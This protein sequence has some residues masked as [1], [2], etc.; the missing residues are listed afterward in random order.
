MRACVYNLLVNRVP[1][2]RDRYQKRRNQKGTSRLTALLFLLW[3]NVQ[4]YLLF[5]RELAFPERYPVYEE[6][7]LPEGESESSRSQREDPAS[8]AEKLSRCDVVSFDVFDTLLLRVV[9][10]PTDVFFFVGMS[11]SY[12]NFRAIRVEMEKKVREQKRRDT[13]SGEV[14]LAEIWDGVAPETGID[15]TLGMQTE[16]WWEK[17]CC[18][19][20]PYMKQVVECLRAKG[21][22]IIAVS[23]MYLSKGHI[24]SL[25]SSCGYPSVLDCF[26][27]CE[28]GV[29]KGEGTLFDRV[30]EQVGRSYSYVHV[31]DHEHADYHQPRRHHMQAFLSLNVN[32]IG[33]R[34]RPS[35]M[36]AITGAVYRG[37]ANAHLHNG[38]TAYS[39]EYEYGYLYGGLFVTGYCRFIHRYAKEHGMQRLLFLS[40]DGAVLLKAYR[41]MYPQEADTAVYAYWSRLA[42]VKLAARYYKWEYFQR[43]LYHKVD[44]QIPLSQIVKSMELS[45]MLPDLCRRTHTTPETFLTNKNVHSVQ[46]YF[47]EA[48]E[49]VLA[50]YEPQ[51]EAGKAY[52]QKLLHGC[53][54]AAAIDVGWAG[55]GAVM[56][57]CMVNRVWGLSCPITGILAGGPS[58]LSPQADG[59]EPF[60]LNGKLV[61]Y[62]YSQRENR[63]LWKFHDPAQSHNLYWE[64]LLGAPHGSLKGF[65]WDGD[66]KATCRFQ[67]SPKEP[68][69]IEEIHRGVLAFVEQFLEA[70]R[71]LAMEIPISGRDAYAPMLLA[72]SRGNRKFRKGLEELLDDVHIG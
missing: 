5:R 53:D 33:N 50:Q 28:Y 3:L 18:I 32:H 11:L 15:K 10:D 7:R 20:N 65:Y 52:Y 51:R 16:L 19:A 35:D 58:A 39:K 69:R 70:E 71:R 14:T 12:P 55:S 46:S 6:R 49:D 44:Q 47:L 62:L 26:I 72:C 37:L 1:G 36:S 27:S 43:F 42:A 4:Y 48:F 57:D 54:R 23:D 34:Y 2:I 41:L 45:C 17:A 38:L 64:L 31:G 67:A 21:K 60:F 56:L 63:D 68:Q 22:K 59:A 29:S 25:L 8:F 40:R 30:Q 61:S 13:G 9:S 66:G 24:R